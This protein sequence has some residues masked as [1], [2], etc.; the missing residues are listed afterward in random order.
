[1]Q[2]ILF[3]YA[4]LRAVR[5]FILSVYNLLFDNP[6]YKGKPFANLVVTVSHK[7]D[8]DIVPKSLTNEAE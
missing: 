2:K 1:M 6:F 3:L 4:S 5:S 7:Y 8:S